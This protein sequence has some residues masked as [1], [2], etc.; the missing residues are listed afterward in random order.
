VKRRDFLK[1]FGVAT[2]A[3]PLVVLDAAEPS[4]G[5]RRRIFPGGLLTFVDGESDEAD[6]RYG[7]M[8]FDKLR[9]TP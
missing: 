3:A 6:D 4:A 7:V 5:V 9:R 2:A 8:I 1:A